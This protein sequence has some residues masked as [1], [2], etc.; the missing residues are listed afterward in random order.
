MD[1]SALV[2]PPPVLR[3]AIYELIVIQPAPI[4]LLRWYA[5]RGWNAQAISNS[6]RHSLALTQTCKQIHAKYGKI[7]YSC[8][9]FEIDVALSSRRK[10]AR[11]S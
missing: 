11:L 6:G 3:N 7:I 1:H 4:E 2:R 5:K 10:S 8:H 9:V